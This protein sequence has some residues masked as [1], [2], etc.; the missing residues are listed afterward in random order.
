[1]NTQV[2][3]V[4]FRYMLC[5]FERSKG[6]WPVSTSIGATV[7][8]PVQVGVRLSGCLYRSCNVEH[9]MRAPPC[10]GGVRTQCEWFGRCGRCLEA[11]SQMRRCGFPPLW[12]ASKRR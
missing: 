10:F 11:G 4:E 5:E 12:G 1:M 2:D 9:G 8:T 7:S 3:Y 6:T